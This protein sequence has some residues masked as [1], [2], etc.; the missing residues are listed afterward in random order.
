MRFSITSLLL[1]FPL[2]IVAQSQPNKA[3]L[4]QYLS[5]LEQH[6]KAVVSI[7]ISKA[8]KVVYENANG[9][10]SAQ[11]TQRINPSTIFRIGSITKTFTATIIFQLIDEGKLTINSKM[12]QFFPDFKNADQITIAHLL[13]HRSG[14]SNYTDQADF[15]NYIDKA[16]SKQELLAHM[17]RM[18]SDFTPGTKTKY[19][20]TGYAML[21]LIIEQLT[22]QTY[23][24]NLQS[25][26]IGKLNLDHTA[27]G[28]AIDLDKNEAKSVMFQGGNWID[29]PMEGNMTVPFSAGAIVSNPQ[30]L[31][32]FLYSLFNDKLISESSLSKMKEINNGIGH[33]LFAVPFYSKKAYGHGGRIDNFITGSYYFPE[34][35]INVT[36]LTSGLTMEFN[37]LLIGV[38]SMTF[39]RDYEIPNFD[40]KTVTLEANTLP[41]YEG[42]FSSDQIPLKIVIKAQDGNLTAQAT[43]QSAFPL[44]ATSKTEFKYDTAGIVMVFKSEDSNEDYEVF[45]LNQ[46][47][48]KFTFKKDK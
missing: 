10:L 13:S 48:Q 15:V 47:G 35:D 14:M 31:N 36:V 23:S 1:L 3:K 45:I 11:Q 44:T 34:D 38:L 29:F 30:N 6:N 19:S 43:G 8:D 27:Y 21:G 25:R 5:L 12:S 16:L 26:I 37:D 32:H 9:Y 46:G 4:D 39:N 28:D 2:L 33:G 20:N 17:K 40:Q 18:P 24:E 41:L 22:N 42:N 7:A